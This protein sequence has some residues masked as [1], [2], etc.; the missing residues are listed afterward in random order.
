MRCWSA[1]V[2]S[3]CSGRGE[4]FTDVARVLRPGGQVIVSYSNRCF[5]TKAV[6][7]WLS[8]DMAGR[9]ALV[10]GYL[11]AAG[12]GDVAVEVLTDGRAKDP[13]VAVEGRAG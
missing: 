11:E 10:A 2:C 3:T 1:W 9:A 6:T 5:Y 12:L 13:L 4:V 7:A 8:R